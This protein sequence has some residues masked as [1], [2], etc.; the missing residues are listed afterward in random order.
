[1]RRV[2]RRN[3]LGLTGAGAL[4]SA[5]TFCLLWGVI[6]LSMPSS[7]V[8]TDD[9]ALA[10]VIGTGVV[11]AGLGLS[12]WASW[13]L[14]A[15]QVVAPA[16]ALLL[17]VATSVGWAAVAFGAVLSPDL[18]NAVGRLPAPLSLFAASGMTVPIGL[19]LGVAYFVLRIRQHRSAV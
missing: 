3:G 4:V 13:T 12:C 7:Q 9:S 11:L 2:H 5:A 15:Y 8:E 14:T 6:F 18:L 1:M 10:G 16:W 17:P 19:G